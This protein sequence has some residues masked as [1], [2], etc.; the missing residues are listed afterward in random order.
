ML[1]V[2]EPPAYRYHYFSLSF[3]LYSYTSTPIRLHILWR[4]AL[5]A[6]FMISNSRRQHVNT[7]LGAFICA[8][9]T[10]ANAHFR[11]RQF[12]AHIYIE[13]CEM[14]I[15]RIIEHCFY[16]VFLF[17]HLSRNFDFH[18]SNY[19]FSIILLPKKN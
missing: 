4:T 18:M 10:S 19:V 8:Y 3:P 7:H 1:C 5:H 2:I 17:P 9:M 15:D 14:V 16:L 12:I 6:Q 13:S 11:H